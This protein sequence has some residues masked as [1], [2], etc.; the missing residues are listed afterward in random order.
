[1]R[2]T[3]FFSIAVAAVTA[4]ACAS[5]GS[6]S[7]AGTAPG[8][9]S[10]VGVTKPSPDPRVGLKAGWFDA[11]TA[12]WNLKL[13]SNTRPSK[14]FINPSTPGDRRLVNSDL[15]FYGNY[16][17]QG[18]YSGYQLWDI[19]NPAKVGAQGSVRLPGVAERCLGLQ[20]RQH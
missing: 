4:G 20:E 18:N 1:M 10:T 11:G 16:V 7:S 9:N 6:S 14:D 12:A 2:P 13:V 5:S 17:M 15:A 8:P 3:S 19:S